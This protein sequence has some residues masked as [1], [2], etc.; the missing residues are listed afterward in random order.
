MYDM[1]HDKVHILIELLR[2]GWFWVHTIVQINLEKETCNKL[3]ID[4]I[5]TGLTIR[6]GLSSIEFF[7]RAWTIV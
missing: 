7:V 5:T 3:T 2:S 4:D 1:L 6:I